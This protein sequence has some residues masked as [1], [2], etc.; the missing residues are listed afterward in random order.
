VTC[1]LVVARKPRPTWR[2]GRLPEVWSLPS[3]QLRGADGTLGQR[4]DDPKGLFR[5]SYSSSK[6]IGP[7][8][9]LLAKLRADDQLVHADV[10]AGA[11]DALA[12]AA[13]DLVHSV[14]P[15]YLHA[16]SWAMVRGIGRAQLDGRFTDIGHHASLSTLHNELP[17]LR[18]RFHLRELDLAAVESDVRPLT[19]TIAGFVF[20]CTWRPPGSPIHVRQFDGIRYESR[21]GSNVNNWAAFEPVALRDIEER[22]LTPDDP[23]LERAARIYR[24]TLL[25]DD[26]S[27]P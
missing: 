10:D 8:L 7:L 23:D 1:K 3:W 5:V 17:E 14:R 16:P 18:R 6:R 4:W 15:G 20:G 12:E 2:V 19:Q 22:P 26:P 9:E 27:G 11:I 24:L 13:G 25:F 21:L